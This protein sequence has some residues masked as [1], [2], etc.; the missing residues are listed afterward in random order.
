MARLRYAL[1][2]LLLLLLL[3]GPGALAGASAPAFTLRDG[4]GRV[5]TLADHAGHPVVLNFWATWCAPCMLEIPALSAFAKDNP[6]VAVLGVTVDSGQPRDM[7]GIRQ[8]LGIRYQIY[9]AT[10]RILADYGVQGVPTTVVLTEKGDISS[11]WSGAITRAELEKL[12]EKARK[13]TR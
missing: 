9:A 13:Q 3:P 6:D 12:V 4:G 2:L 8:R 1:A 11:T 10:Q 5:V 7:A